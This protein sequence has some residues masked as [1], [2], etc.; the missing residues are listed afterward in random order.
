MRLFKVLLSVVIEIEGDSPELYIISAAQFTSSSLNLLIS[1]FFVIYEKNSL[2]Q[3]T[4][5]EIERRI[6]QQTSRRYSDYLQYDQFLVIRKPSSTLRS[7]AFILAVK[8]QDMQAASPPL[9]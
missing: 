6:G 7:Q 3:K 4:P 8:E 2:K 9:H 5:L 1:M